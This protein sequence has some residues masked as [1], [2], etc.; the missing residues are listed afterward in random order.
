MVDEQPDDFLEEA[1]LEDIGNP[2]ALL[3]QRS[4]VLHFPV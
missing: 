1:R 3:N 4:P 2:K